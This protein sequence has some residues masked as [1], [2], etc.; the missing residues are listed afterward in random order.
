MDK[1]HKRG[2]PTYSLTKTKFVYGWRC[3]K[4]LWLREYEKDAPE[5]KL[6]ASKRDRMSQGIAVGIAAQDWFDGVEITSG[7]NRQQK[8]VSETLDALE[9]GIPA[10]FEA[11][12]IEDGVF[13]AVDVLE[14]LDSGYR[15]LEV[16]ASAR[17]KPEHIPDLAVQTHVLRRAGLDIRQIAVM[18]LNPSYRKH[19]TGDLFVI[20]DVSDQV[21]AMI[22]EV[23]MLIGEYKEC[24]T[25]SQPQI[26]I[27]DHCWKGRDWGRDCAFTTRCWPQEPD[28]IKRL[29]GIGPSR[30]VK[31]MG[32][33]V[34]SFSDVDE[35]TKVPPEARRQIRAWRVGGLLV[36]GDLSA[37][38]EPFK[39]VVGFLDFETVQRAIP[40]WK[41]TKPW[42][43][44]PVQFSYHERDERGAYQHTE[45]LTDGPD[46]PRRGLAEAL[47]QATQNA[48]NVAMY[49][50]YERTCV[51]HLIEAVPDLADELTDL[52]DRLIDLKKVLKNHVAHPE[53]GGSFSIKDTLAPLSGDTTYAEL[54]VAD[55]A[56]AM[57]ELSNLILSGDSLSASEADTKRE[58]LLAYCAQDTWAMVEL[59]EKLEELALG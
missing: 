1:T 19:E 47:V 2:R 50:T 17:N 18:H 15:L 12:F 33:G 16:K 27:G 8:M 10:I 32:Q 58:E 4:K 39:G 3:K 57:V 13:V 51:N 49:S 46:D 11:A 42:E 53:F 9:K 29:S 36:E 31:L 40:V 38:L 43:A 25:G 28:H 48:G 5:L 22:D 52:R 21:E 24:L 41:G 20:T 54:T 6:D 26:P 34:E 35:D 30:A 55:G 56:T 37:A 44:V 14:R 45:W 59:L 7:P 23:P